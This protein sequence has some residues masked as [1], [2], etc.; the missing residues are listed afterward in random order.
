MIDP[1][2]KNWALAAHLTGLTI[3]MGIP[4]GNLLGPLVVYLMKKDSTPFATEH[5][6]EALNFQISMT[7]YYIMAFMMTLLI[8]GFVLIVALC[9]LHLTCCII[10]AVRAS[11]GEMYRYPLTIRLVS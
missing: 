11:N 7:L 8:V 4:F 1:E 5:A 2:E 3:F 10:A 9:V 6:R